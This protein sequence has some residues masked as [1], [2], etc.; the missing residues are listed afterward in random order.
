MRAKLPTIK[1]NPKTET[2]VLRCCKAD[3]TSRDRF[4]WPEKGTIKAPDFS[5]TPECGQ[6]LHGWARGEGDFGAWSSSP[7]DQWLVLAVKTTSLIDLGGKVKFPSARVLFCGERDTA[8]ALIQKHYP[9]AAVIYGTAT[10]GECGTAT[11]GYRGTATAGYRGT[12]TAGD[13]GTATAGECGTATAGECG[14]AT[15]G[16]YGTATAGYGGTATAGECGILQIKTWDSECSRCRI[17]TG[18]I[19]EDGL[20]PNTKYK[21]NDKARFVEA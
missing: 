11:A 6:G 18:Y 19:G 3:M 10:A 5:K 15:A 8:V 1:F 4:K 17:I 7:D 21:L 20:K 2:L 16:E 13:R 12:A 14:T 9:D